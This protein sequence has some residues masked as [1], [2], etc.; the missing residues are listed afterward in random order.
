MFQL[1]VNNSAKSF[2]I[3]RFKALDGWEIQRRFVE[4]AASSDRKFRRDFTLEILSYAHVIT[5]T[6]E[7]PLSTDALI[8]N[9]L[10]SWENVQALFEEILRVNGIDPATHADAPHFWA[11]AG[12]EMATSFLAACTQIMGPA[13][14]LLDQQN[15]G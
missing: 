4:F 6:G 3:D 10:G 9:H 8:D 12:E 11:K 15:K 5:D 14:Q 13:L 1:E 7:L 2:Q